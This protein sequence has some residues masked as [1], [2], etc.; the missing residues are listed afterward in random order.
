MNIS[1]WNFQ[2]LRFLSRFCNLKSISWEKLLVLVNL[3]QC[4]IGFTLNIQFPNDFAHLPTAHWKVVLIELSFLTSRVPCL[5]F[6]LTRLSQLCSNFLFIKCD[7]SATERWRHHLRG[8]AAAGHRIWSF[9]S[10][11]SG[12]RSQAGNW[13]SVRAGDYPLHLGHQLASHLPH[14]P[15]KRRYHQTVQI[16]SSWCNAVTQCSIDDLIFQAMSSDRVLVPDDLSP[17]LP[18]SQLVRPTDS[19]WSHKHDSDDNDLKDYRRGIWA[20]RCLVEAQRRW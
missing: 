8:A 1:W 7:G 10:E 4:L 12:C 5:V 15:H 3:F 20:E 2:F 18:D 13:N 19:T 6:I 16:V 11:N 14:V 9:L 17:L